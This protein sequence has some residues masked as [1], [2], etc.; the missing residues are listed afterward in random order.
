MD[1][2]ARAAAFPGV[3]LIILA[4]LPIYVIDVFAGHPEFNLM[5][6]LGIGFGILVSG[7]TGFTFGAI[8]MAIL[9]LCA[10]VGL[11]VSV[12]PG[13]AI[14]FMAVVG[15]LGMLA[16]RR[17]D[18]VILGVTSALVGNWVFTPNLALGK[19]PTGWSNVVAVG[20]LVGLGGLWGCGVGGTLKLKLKMPTAP[21][22]PWRHAITAGIMT[23]VVYAVGTQ[24]IVDHHLGE[25]GFWFL[26]TIGVVYQPFALHP[27]IKTGYRVVGTVI[28]VI[29]AVVVTFVLPSDAGDV[30]FMLAGL[31]F[32]SIYVHQTLRPQIAYWKSVVSL[33][34]GLM[35]I[36]G[37]GGVTVAIGDS[38]RHLAFIRLN[39]TLC[40]V[41]VSLVMTAI[42]VVGAKL[43]RRDLAE[44]STDGSTSAEPSNS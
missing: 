15:L 25:G 23:A 35:L 42:V 30:A 36:L 34:S 1:I 32:L 27:W 28:G 8:T 20:L 21:G 18:T 9:G 4:V 17:T 10:S 5:A 16:K 22:Q 3:Y 2:K 43:L 14:A 7:L 38:I 19:V 12:R 24:V 6:L 39:A 11:L 40:G 33:T 37:S 31:A 44:P 41:G 13:A 26:L 29:V